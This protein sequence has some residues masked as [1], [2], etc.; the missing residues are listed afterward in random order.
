VP[1]RDAA[2][3]YRNRISA[4]IGWNEKDGWQGRW[5]GRILS[6]MGLLVREFIQVDKTLYKECGNPI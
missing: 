1:S 3:E 5:L 4:Y 2:G 6:A